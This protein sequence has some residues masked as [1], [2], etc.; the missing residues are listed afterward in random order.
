MKKRTY[1]YIVECSN[2]INRLSDYVKAQNHW[3]AENQVEK[4]YFDKYQ[5]YPTCV[6]SRKSTKTECKNLFL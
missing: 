4:K 6:E 3:D 1:Y 2:G 5:E